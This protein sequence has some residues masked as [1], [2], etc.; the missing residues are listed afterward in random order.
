MRERHNCNLFK[1]H[2]IGGS[3]Q[4]SVD[5]AYQ[6]N[7]AARLRSWFPGRRD[8]GASSGCVHYVLHF[9]FLFSISNYERWT[10]KFCW[11]AAANIN[12]VFH[13]ISSRR[14]GLRTTNASYALI[15]VDTILYDIRFFFFWLLWIGCSRCIDNS[16]SVFYVIIPVQVARNI[17]DCFKHF[18]ARSFRLIKWQVDG[19]VLKFLRISKIARVT[20]DTLSN[21]KR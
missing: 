13:E 2:N 12:R 8:I 18:V 16:R 6:S 15:S 11:T 14:R 1:W 17:T 9:Y 21:K 19:A 5:W 7:D 3:E 10:L 4:H 20:L